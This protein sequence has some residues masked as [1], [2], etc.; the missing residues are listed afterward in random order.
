M[1]PSHTVLVWRPPQAEHIARTER[2]TGL[3]IY[4]LDNS[5][6]TAA[7]DGKVYTFDDQDNEASP[8]QII[9]QSDQ[10]DATSGFI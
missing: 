8:F 10:N 6:S 1:L 9:N 3:R 4:V 5:G 2:N 7:L